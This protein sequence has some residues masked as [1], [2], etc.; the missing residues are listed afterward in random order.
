MGFEFRESVFFW[1]LVTAAVFFGLSN[2]S[3]TLNRFMFSA[4]FFGVQ[5]YSPGALIMSLHYYHV[6]LDFCEINSVFEGIF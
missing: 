6:M 2:K 3:C 4:V 1:V 5:F